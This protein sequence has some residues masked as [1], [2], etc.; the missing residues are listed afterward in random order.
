MTCLDC[1]M[2]PKRGINGQ[3]ILQ[4]YKKSVT[5]DMMFSTVLGQW[6]ASA[7]TRHYPGSCFFGC[8]QC[9]TAKCWSP[10]WFSSECSDSFHCKLFIRD[11]L[12]LCYGITSLDWP[13]VFQH[14]SV[15]SI[16]ASILAITSC[17]L[18]SVWEAGLPYPLF[19][20]SLTS[21]H[22]FSIGSYFSQQV[23]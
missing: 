16:Q 9:S 12:V 19:N 13:S 7:R 3:Y 20:H 22:F 15:P 21:S 17:W 10:C 14:A 6:L 4:K 1:L 18:A 23:F 11:F 5:F 8:Q 2:L